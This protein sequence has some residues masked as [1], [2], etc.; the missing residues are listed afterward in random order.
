MGNLDCKCLEFSDKNAYSSTFRKKHKR[1][2]LRDREPDSNIQKLSLK[3]ILG[4]M[5]FQR[6]TDADNIFAKK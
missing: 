5:D 4:E 3:D 1:S 6:S 2:T